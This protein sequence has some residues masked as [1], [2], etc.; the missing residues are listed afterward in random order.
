MDG[1]SLVDVYDSIEYEP[2]VLV[3]GE[4]TLCN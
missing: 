2:G 1:V 3:V 4:D